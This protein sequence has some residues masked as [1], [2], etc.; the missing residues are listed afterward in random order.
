MVKPRGA[1][2]GKVGCVVEGLIV[3][4]RALAEIG[5]ALPLHLPETAW[6]IAV[7]RVNS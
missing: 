5:L 3:S 2:S 6:L 7:E 1:L 4:G